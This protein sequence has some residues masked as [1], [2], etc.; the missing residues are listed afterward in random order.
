MLARDIVSRF[1][2]EMSMR[3]C[4]APVLISRR[5]RR[6]PPRSMSARTAP[7]SMFRSIA[8]SRDN[9]NSISPAPRSRMDRKRRPML[10]VPIWSERSWY[11]AIGLKTSSSYSIRMW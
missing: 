3:V 11:S 2:S 8:T 6:I 7:K 1:G 10:S 9:A 4:D 5:V